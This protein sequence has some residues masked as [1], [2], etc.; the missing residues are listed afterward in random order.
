M[1][2]LKDATDR[3]KLMIDTIP[4]NFTFFDA[5]RGSDISR[6]QKNEFPIFLGSNNEL[7][8]MLSHYNLWQKLIDKSSP[9]LIL[10]DDA[11]FVDNIDNLDL[12]NDF[13]IVFFGHCF[14]KKGQII[15]EPIYKSVQPSC[16]HGYL[17]SQKGIKKLLDNFNK[18]NINNPIDNYT[19]NLI[20]DNKL[21]SYSL[22]PQYII[23][24]NIPSQIDVYNLRYIYGKLRSLRNSLNEFFSYVYI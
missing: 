10:E 21:I 20:K 14:E 3:R 9:T 6:E 19:M 13:D 5:V 15:K 7:G 16:L 1:I 8:C 12:P 4:Y 11:E 17:V 23:Q 22:F 24:K 18:K 2:S